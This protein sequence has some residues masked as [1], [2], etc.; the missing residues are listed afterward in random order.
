M[1]VQYILVENKL[2]KDMAMFC[3][4]HGL[5]YSQYKMQTL[6]YMKN[7]NDDYSSKSF[8]QVPVIAKNDYYDLAIDVFMDIQMQ[9]ESDSYLKYVDYTFMDNSEILEIAKNHFD[10]IQYV[11]KHQFKL[12]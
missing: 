12:Y 6:H 3:I 7:L 9:V 8:T 10:L 5:T 1:S 11:F 4:K 2:S